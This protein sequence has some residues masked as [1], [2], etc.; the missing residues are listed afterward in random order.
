MT[1]L[2]EPER[3]YALNQDGT[4]AAE[5]TFPI[6]NNVADINHT[7]VDPELR[8]RGIAGQLMEAAVSHLRSKGVQIR[9]TC[10]Y[11]AKWFLEHPEYQELLEVSRL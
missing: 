8:G 6:W 5:V 4:L 2:Y 1:F 7:F 3:I 10:P 9:P 11:A